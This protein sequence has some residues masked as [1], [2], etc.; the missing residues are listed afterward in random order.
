MKPRKAQTL[1]PRPLS[2]ECGTHKTVKAMFWPWLS[3]KLL[4]T[5][6][7]VP[8]SLGR[9]SRHAKGWEG[10]VLLKE[11]GT[12]VY[13]SGNSNLFKHCPK[14]TE[15]RMQRSIEGVPPRRPLRVRLPTPDGWRGPI[16]SGHVIVFIS[17]LPGAWSH[18]GSNLSI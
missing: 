15:R 7:G 17:D 4:K 1:F 5:F 16:S 13:V 14:S 2:R 3:G 12:T 10:V 9:G 6:Q 18:P 8:S 11:P